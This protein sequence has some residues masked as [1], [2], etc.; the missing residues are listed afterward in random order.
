M[1]EM[2]GRIKISGDLAIIEID[3]GG[4]YDIPVSYIV[5]IISNVVQ[6]PLNLENMSEG[7]AS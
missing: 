3:G 5:D 1:V 2:V 7:L 6:I 4:V